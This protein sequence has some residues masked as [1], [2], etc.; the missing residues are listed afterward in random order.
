MSVVLSMSANKR[1]TCKVNESNFKGE[2][3]FEY[4]TVYLPVTYKNTNML[5]YT[6]QLN[7]INDDSVGDCVTLSNPTMEN[8]RYKYVFPIPIKWTYKVGKMA[9]W[10]KFLKDDETAGLTNEV[11]AEILDSR[12]V[13]DYIPEQSL[14]LLDEWTLKMEETNNKVQKA[15]DELK[16]LVREDDYWIMLGHESEG[17]ANAE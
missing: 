13:V 1:L 11:Y 15:I 8:E 9:L 6:T 12:E 3:K 14:S 17:D 5:D 4:I 2:N 10:L 16:N 7:I